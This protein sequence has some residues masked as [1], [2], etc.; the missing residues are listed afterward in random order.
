MFSITVIWAA[1]FCYLIFL[2]ILGFLGDKYL[3]KSKPHPV[4]YSLA[5]GVHCTSWAFFGT[6]TQA[7]QYGWGFVPTYLGVILVMLFGYKA[8]QH[9]ARLCRD[10]NI[11]SLA[12][13][14]GFQYQQSYSLMALVTL[15]CFVGV[16]PYVALQLDSVSHNVALITGQ[17]SG[18]A[19]LI[20]TLTLAILAV[21]L[22]AR[23]Y[24]TFEKKPGLMLTIAFASLFKIIAITSVGIFVCYILFDGIFDLLGKAQN[25]DN[26]QTI[27]R[28]DS[29]VFVFISHILLGVCAM[30]CLPRQFHVNFVEN[31]S[32]QELETARW[33]FPVYLVGMA[34]FILP[35]GLAGHMLFEPSIVSTDTYALAL[36]M[37][38]GNAF[39]SLISFLGGF[40]AAT[41]M[42][43]V[44]TLA[45][46]IMISNSLI[47]PVW[48]KLT[49]LNK[50]QSRLTPSAI[51]LIRRLTILSVLAVAYFYHRDVSSGSPLVNSGIIAMSLLAQTLPM[52]LLGL[53]WQNVS[54]TAVL[55]G[56]LVGFVCW[57][58]LL[59]WPSI[60]SSYYFNPIPT[61]FELGR[62]FIVSLFANIICV[63]AVSW[64][65]PKNARTTHLRQI[66]HP[67]L[68]SGSI[69]TE[70]LL[71][72]TQSVLSHEEQSLL[73]REATE[74]D[75]SP[76]AT[77]A[78]IANV[79]N[80]LAGKIGG[81]SARILVSALAQKDQ[82]TLPEI[83]EW[84]EEATQ[85]FQF[86]QEILRSSVEHI[87]QGICVM[88][89]D[90]KLVAWNQQYVEM[91]KY[92]EDFIRAGVSMM[93]ILE[94][95]AKRKLFGDASN[96]KQE[97]D[98][99]LKFTRQGS[100][101]KYVRV[102]PNGQVIELNGSPLPGGGFVT[103]YSDITEYIEIQ[104]ALESAKT[105]LEQRVEQRT[106]QLNESNQ[107]LAQA[108]SVAEKANESKTK[109]LAAAGHDLM[110]PL[111][112]A[113]LF[114]QL[115]QQQA[116]SQEISQLS[117]SLNDSLSSAEELL[118]LLLDMTK[119][120]SGVLKAKHEDFAVDDVLAP[121]FAEFSIIAEQKGL[122]ITYVRSRAVV[123]SDKKLL[124]RLVQNLLSNAIRY[125]DTGK[126]LLGCRLTF[127]A[128]K[129]CVLDTG[130]GISIT[131]QKVIFDEF[132][133][134]DNATSHQG[135]GLG[136][137]I[138]D[139][140]SSLLGHPVLLNSEEHKG[141]QFAVE[142]KRVSG[143]SSKV[144]KISEKQKA[145][146]FLTGKYILLAENDLATQNAVKQLLESW[147]AVVMVANTLTDIDKLTTPIDLMLLDYHLDRELTGIDI[148]QAMRSK[149]GSTLS[150]ILNTAERSDE[151]R[152]IAQLNNLQ[153]LPK[154]LK[155][156]ALK[157]TLRALLVH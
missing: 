98:K 16:I 28:A 60:T 67:S 18:L 117:Q 59:L 9:I 118:S 37:E 34:I 120:E 111:N 83:A 150:G 154:P 66:R 85:T 126:I 103:T 47:T 133:Q 157:R 135:L 95:N 92:P 88:D 39:I 64:L 23:S 2:F 41:S 99:R 102:Q 17:Q 110:Q 96:S 46:A 15:L 134:L 149:F 115:I 70:K 139:K 44:A 80:R 27:L 61:D 4:L 65:S 156:A 140:I 63:C 124:R 106:E 6:T 105:D 58:A 84:V 152:A 29:G 143:K 14:V 129:I 11:S 153:Y 38:A 73:E 89:P 20:V 108:K 7:T 8:L 33:A 145:G 155:S 50:D 123:H 13:F 79:E 116:S 55:S 114:A 31:K 72:L 49:L 144:R 127:D 107:A 147:G 19:S 12:D 74:F 71:S 142:V 93:E 3:S 112:A 40:A 54:K 100:P 22:G 132:R 10:N 43:V 24:D 128:V 53:Y 119:L 121:L 90:M 101:Y 68:L 42:V 51:L 26:A 1:L 136:L 5:L 77:S 122:K 91:F 87:K 25:S 125:T 48:I 146:L 97:I 21:F 52:I 32:A 94:F 56:L 86:N 104:N 113:S 141:S 151:I 36:P 109:F 148:C 35:I 76:F 62:G 75:R 137:T 130:T 45:V 30:F 131:N 82:Q 78:F 138:V 57:C 81:A 69:P